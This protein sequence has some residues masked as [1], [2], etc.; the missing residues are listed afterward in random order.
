MSATDLAHDDDDDNDDNVAVVVVVVVV[1]FKLRTHL[2]PSD[3][4]IQHTLEGK[5]G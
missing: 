1:V 3:C 5:V 4:C 2:A